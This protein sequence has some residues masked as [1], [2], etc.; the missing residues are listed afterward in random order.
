MLGWRIVGGCSLVALSLNF[1]GLTG[2]WAW[3]NPSI[4]PAG[5]SFL[6]QKKNYVHFFKKNNR[7]V[8]ASLCIPN[9]GVLKVAPMFDLCEIQTCDFLKVKP[10][11]YFHILTRRNSLRLDCVQYCGDI[12]CIIIRGNQTYGIRF[13]WEKT[14]QNS[15]FQIIFACMSY[16]R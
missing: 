14:K 4:K 6:C 16:I 5:Y 7:N 3:Y 13:L 12:V 2:L 15:R 1:W 11:S 10:F 9:S 8:W